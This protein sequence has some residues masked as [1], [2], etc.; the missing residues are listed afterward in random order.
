VTVSQDQQETI[1]I[2]TPRVR[3][4]LDVDGVLNAL[5][6]SDNRGPWKDWRFEMVN[7]FGITWSPT[8]AKFIRTLTGQG[9]DVRWLTTWGHNANDFL[10][11]V[12]DLPQFPVVAEYAYDSGPRWWKL[13]PAQLLYE[14][15]P[16]PFVWIDD[17]L[18][19]DF[20]AVEW[21]ATLPADS[22]LAVTPDPFTGLNPDH[23]DSISAF[24]NL[25]L[26]D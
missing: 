16:V 24:V 18:D 15:D 8:V 6:N 25:R 11:A 12:L 21:L 1:D 22:H 20:E 17:D 2:V 26:T 19:Y 10:C 4:L 13:G 9:V 5:S 3:L 7:G 14:L 23:V